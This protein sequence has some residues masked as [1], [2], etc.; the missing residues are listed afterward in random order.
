MTDHAND[1]I[2][3]DLVAKGHIPLQNSGGVLT[4]ETGSGTGEK[5]LAAGNA[6]NCKSVENLDS[7]G[8]GAKTLKSSLAIGVEIPPQQAPEEP[9]GIPGAYALCG[10]MD[11]RTEQATDLDLSHGVVPTVPNNTEIPSA[12]PVED[13]ERAEE[14]VGHR[15][16]PTR[17]SDKIEFPWAL[18]CWLVLVVIA[19]VIPTVLLREPADGSVA[20]ATSSSPSFAPSPSP[21][22]DFIL[23]LPMHTKEAILDDPESSQF[24]AYQWLQND[25]NRKNYTQGKLMQRFVLATLYYATNGRME[26]GGRGA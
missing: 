8:T 1:N 16:M 13:L 26:V 21:T 7:T 15:I 18:G 22:I 10:V 14:V 23:D 17:G 19:I 20:Q 2:V 25:P 3:D 11:E 5:T 6:S 4:E 24:Q 9:N 12:T